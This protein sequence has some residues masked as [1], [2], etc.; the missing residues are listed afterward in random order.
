MNTNDELAMRKE[1]FH[2]SGIVEAYQCKVCIIYIYTLMYR[3]VE[4]VM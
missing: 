2:K 3:C 4:K 1:T